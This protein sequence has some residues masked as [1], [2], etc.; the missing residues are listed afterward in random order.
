MMLDAAEPL[1]LPGFFPE[2]RPI[3]AQR[4]RLRI[5]QGRLDDARAWAEE[6]RVRLDA[7][8]SYLA[9]FDQLTLA[10]LLLAEGAA[11]DGDLERVLGA[12]VGAAQARGQIGSALDAQVVLA[13]AAPRPRRPRRCAL[14]A[15]PGSGPR[16]AGR[17]PA[18]V[19]RRGRADG[20]AAAGSPGTARRTRGT[21]RGGADRRRR[22]RPATSP[23]SPRTR[24]SA[25]ASSR[26]CGS[27]RPS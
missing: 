13:L 12:L 5:A 1:Y 16:R 7:T 4:A 21:A 2:L 8:A 14:R 9:T 20:G 18:A 23:R 26:C 27:S 10:R 15:R 11:D 22:C 6:H 19:P 24:T 17:L 25:S 3:P